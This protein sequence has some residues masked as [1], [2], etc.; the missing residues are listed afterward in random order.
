MGIKHP[1]K[2]TTHSCPQRLSRIIV[3]MWVVMI[4]ISL[5]ENKLIYGKNNNKVA[6]GY[7]DNRHDKCQN[8]FFSV[9]H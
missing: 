9:T 1:G 7:T 5:L 3:W 6:I 8:V 2:G 4:M